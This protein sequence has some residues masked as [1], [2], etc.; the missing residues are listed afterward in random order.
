M[1]SLTLQPL[2][3]RRK[4]R[5]YQLYWKLHGPDEV[6]AGI[7]TPDRSARSLVNILTTRQWWWWWWWWKVGGANSSDGGRCGT[8]RTKVFLYSNQAKRHDRVWNRD[9]GSQQ[10]MQP[11]DL[12]PRSLN[13]QRKYPRFSQWAPQPIWTLRKK[14]E[15]IPRPSS[16]QNN[17]YTDWATA[18]P[19]TSNSNNKSLPSVLHYLYSPSRISLLFILSDSPHHH[20]HSN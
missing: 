10:Y 7:R 15:T 2:Y 5:R 13:P 12:T 18:A 16:S 1:V 8:H 14:T 19:W 3:L 17:H 9:T 20:H 4:N 6:S 11:S